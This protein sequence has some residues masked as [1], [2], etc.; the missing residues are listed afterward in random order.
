MLG[1]GKSKYKCKYWNYAPKFQ[2]VKVSTG[3]GIVTKPKILV[4]KGK[5]K[6]GYF[7]LKWKNKPKCNTHVSKKPI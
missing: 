3:V 5:Y 1:F 7:K 2:L 6:F 4:G